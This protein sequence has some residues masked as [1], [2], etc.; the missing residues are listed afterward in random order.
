MITQYYPP[1]ITAAAFRINDMV[2]ALKKCGFDVKIITSKPHKVS[3]QH[4]D[5]L[6]D[7]DYVIRLWVPRGV[8]GFATRVNNYLTFAIMAIIKGILL[9]G[10]F[11]WVIV[12]SPPLFLSVTGYAL[13]KIKKAKYFAD[14]RDI[15]PDSVVAAKM[16][17]EE[18]KSHKFFLLVENWFYRRADNLMCVSKFMSEYIFTKSGKTAAVIYNGVSNDIIESSLLTTVKKG[19]YFNILYFGNVGRLQGLDTVI[20][21]LAILQHNSTAEIRFTIVG[22]GAEK[23]RLKKKIAQLK[24][25]NIEVVGSVPRNN[26]KDYV[27]EADALLLALD[28]HPATQMTIPSKLFDYLLFNKPVI[29]GIKGE[30][31][32]IIENLGC[33]IIYR[34]NDV[35]HL[36]ESI[37]EII[38][39]YDEFSIKASYNRDYVIKYFNREQGFVSYFSSFI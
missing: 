28:D 13:S 26:L 31:K 1:D 9:K 33:G 19:A 15:W 12:S 17:E 18:S 22:E 10:K 11:D 34:S 5:T 20:D 38:S 24:L 7:G 16:M 23:L 27:T 36:V 21:A 3:V 39:R 4:D 25:S 32:E 35:N 14:V 2:N 6:S 30:G 37:K 8:H 29:A